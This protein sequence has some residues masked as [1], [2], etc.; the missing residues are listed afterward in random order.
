MSIILNVINYFWKLGFNEESPDVYA[1]AY[2]GSQRFLL[3]LHE[4]TFDFGVAVEVLDPSFECFSQKNF[5]VMESLDRLLGRGV[6]PDALRIGG[7]AGLDY[8]VATGHGSVLVAVRCT[9]WEEE[10]DEAVASLESADRLPPS[11][12]SVDGDIEWLVVYTSRLK[13]GLVEHRC[14]WFPKGRWLGGM[15]D[16]RPGI[17]D[18]P[19]VGLSGRPSSEPVPDG[20]FVVRDGVLVEYHGAQEH[21][22]VPSQVHSLAN[23]VFWN[24]E[25]TRTVTLPEGLRSLG[26]DTFYNCRNLEHLQIPSTVEVAGDN[27]FAN[28]PKLV[29]ENRSPHF[30]C[31]DGLLLNREG[32][33]LIYCAIQ[34]RSSSVDVPDGVVSIGKHAFHNCRRLD[35][36]V[37]GE[38]VRIVENNPFSNLPRLRLDNRSAHFVF[39][40]G[41]LYNKTMSTLFYYEHG[42]ESDRLDI[43]EGVKIVGRHSFYNCRGIRSLTIPSTVTVIGYNPFAG[44]SALAIHNESPAYTYRDGALYTGDMAELVHYSISSPRPEFVVPNGVRKIGRSAFFES[45]H[46]TS[47]RLPEGLETIERSAFAGCK[48]LRRVR[49][50]DSVTE[51]GEWAFSDCA[52]LVRLRLPSRASLEAQTFRGCPENASQWSE[53]R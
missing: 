50:P 40:D 39:R 7:R 53:R 23:A 32:T 4:E 52:S 8:T 25:A 22:V 35:R 5:V 2:D 49:I 3:D 33:R 12:Q 27:P 9:I 48:G 45:P 15:A 13:A 31:E 16:A 20:D 30:R 14:A 44:C 41:A 11:F 37:L 38:D 42:W 26:G 47:V 28:C 1:K 6:P 18:E 34:G 10:Y 17:F 21:V 29:L 36:I 43:P 24:T 46:L 51:I 19:E